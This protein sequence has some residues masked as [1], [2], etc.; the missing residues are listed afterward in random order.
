MDTA[1]SQSDWF[2]RPGDSL[3]AAMQ[4]KK[5]APSAV[6]GRLSGGMEQLR[7]LLAGTAEIDEPAAAVIG[8]LV[9]GSVH[10]WLM[11]QKNYNR[12]LERAIAA[13]P[14]AEAKVWLASIPAPGPA[15]R[16]KLDEAKLHAEL[17]RRLAFFG[18]GTLGAWQCKYGRDRD[19]T[20]FRKSTKLSSDDGAISLWLR[21]GELT[22]ALAETAPWNPAALEERM[23]D[24]KRLSRISRPARFL[25]LLKALLAEAGVALVVQ[26]APSECKASG[27]SR[28]ITPERAMILLSFRFRSD[29]Q[30]WFTLFHEIGHL[31][32]HGAQPFVDEEGMAED[33]CERE[34]NA[35]AADLIVPQHRQ[36]E[37]DALGTRYKDITRYAVAVEVAP[38]LVLGQLNHRGLPRNRLTFL[39]R[40]WS[41]AEID[42]AI[43]SL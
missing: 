40:I 28:L 32:L 27:A 43:A 25:P 35:F 20:R 11:R 24:I 37:F 22:A 18:V 29:E 31:L 30:F 9:G 17:R 41:W 21:Q 7:A 3:L 38:G 34:A 13:V 14:E 39:R 1:T 12:D 10:F 33:E 23:A 5:V 36:A 15:A 26:R 16:G 4:R 42:E 8:D 6:A 2:S 19:T